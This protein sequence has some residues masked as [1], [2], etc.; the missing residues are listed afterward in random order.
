M[1]LHLYEGQ[2]TAWGQGKSA[3]SFHHLDPGNQAQVARL[4]GQCLSL[5]CPPGF[6]VVLKLV[7][8]RLMASTVLNCMHVLNLK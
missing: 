6:S 2:K 8:M 4:D 7:F 1:T 3:L 5:G